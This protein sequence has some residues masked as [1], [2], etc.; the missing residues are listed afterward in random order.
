MICKNDKQIRHVPHI[1]PQSEIMKLLCNPKKAKEL[2][3]WEARFSLEEGIEI[4]KNG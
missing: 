2:L 3:G 1:H 4:T